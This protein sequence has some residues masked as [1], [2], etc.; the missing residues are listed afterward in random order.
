MATVSRHELLLTE[1]PSYFWCEFKVSA[2]EL[3]VGQG[4]L[5]AQRS[6]SSSRLLGVQS[7]ERS[8]SG[9]LIASTPGRFRVLECG[10][11]LAGHILLLFGQIDLLAGVLV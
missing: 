9:R 8:T 7:C 3:A 11:Q 4:D 2:T 5:G 1:L 10:C 6:I